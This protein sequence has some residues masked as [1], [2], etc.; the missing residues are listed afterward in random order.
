VDQ[1]LAGKVALVT[2]SG[3]NIGRAVAL[4][5][6]G[7]G[8]DVIVN[9]RSNRDEAESVA[10]E[11][12]ALG[13]RAIAVVA[14]VADR[15]Q[16]R[17]MTERGLA[18]LG[19]IDILVNAAAIRPHAPFLELTPE[20]WGKVRNVV[21]DGAIHCTQAVLPA[22]VDRSDG[23]VLFVVGEGAWGG[24]AERGH[25]GAAKM[26]LIGLCRSLA[27]EFAANG[28]RFNTISPGRIDTVRE[29]GSS[30]TS[31]AGDAVSNIPL[32]RLGH[33]DDIANACLFLVSDQ[34][35]WITGQTLH[36]NG[37]QSYY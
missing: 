1:Q 29:S 16:V 9:S 11:V 28:I 18:E 19:R 7:E 25:I 30:A 17:A 6:A 3:R 37:G 10:A 35:S 2:G 34:S 27:T 14:D 22:M 33:V 24:G 23:R 20:A 31:S 12:R 8:A 15:D 32:G 21:L 4:R 5:F 26:A 13:R 36:V